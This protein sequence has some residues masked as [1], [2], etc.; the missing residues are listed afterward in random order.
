MTVR[1]MRSGIITG[2]AAL[3]AA[4]ASAGGR[5][6]TVGDSSRGAALLTSG[7]PALLP[8]SLA[9][10]GRLRQ[11]PS[12]PRIGFTGVFLDGKEE[13]SISDAVRKA[14]SLIRQVGN[15]GVTCKAGVSATG[16]STAQNCTMLDMDV[17]YRFSTFRVVSDSAYVG[18]ASSSVVG[19]QPEGHAI[20]IVLA[21]QNSEW[22][23][24]RDWKVAH[25]F[26]CGR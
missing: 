6:E 11:I 24:V 18:G 19:G 14:H 9:A 10:G 22:V 17:V 4:C 7:A 15:L 5:A 23:A 20:C 8:L 16:R 3:V 13:M 25:D 26:N 12:G 21:K 2:F 1:L